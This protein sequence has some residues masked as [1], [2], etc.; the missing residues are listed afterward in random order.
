MKIIFLSIF[1]DVKNLSKTVNNRTLTHSGLIH[2]PFHLQLPA[3]HLSL[4]SC[5]STVS[6]FFTQVRTEPVCRLWNGNSWDNLCS[7]NGAKIPASVPR[8]KR[9]LIRMTSLS[10]LLYEKKQLRFPH[11]C[12]K[13]RS[14]QPIGSKHKKLRWDSCTN[15]LCQSEAPLHQK[16][17][18]WGCSY[19]LVHTNDEFGR[20]R[21]I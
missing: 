15:E 13:D 5:S 20:T 21:L 2:S 7:Y 19:I 16:I 9:S 8:G 11:S 6:M 14:I 18:K 3:F 10:S 17:R 1:T 4:L 12:R